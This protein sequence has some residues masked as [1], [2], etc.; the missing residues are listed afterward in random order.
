MAKI[1]KT[2]KSK[3]K[4]N[5]FGFATY[6]FCFAMIC[7][8]ASSLFLKSY[9][10]TLSTKK[11]SIDSQIAALEMQNNSVENEVRQLASA[12]RVDEVAA[13]SG[14]TYNQGNIIS[15]SGEAADGE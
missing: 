9:N 12:D 15:V 1:V 6:L 2:K 11:Q 10:N 8:L 13:N 14:L 3:R 4:L 7:F 5:L